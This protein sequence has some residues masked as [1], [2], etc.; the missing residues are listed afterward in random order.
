[1]CAKEGSERYMRYKIMKNRC[2]IFLSAVFGKIDAKDI[3]QYMIDH[4]FT[5]ARL[6]LQM[7]KYIWEP[8]QHG[9]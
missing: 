9:V 1:M 7:H 8:D 2:G 3:V 6:Q 5:E 4:H